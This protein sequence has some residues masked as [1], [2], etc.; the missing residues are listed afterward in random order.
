MID[1][2]TDCGDSAPAKLTR[3]FS[4]T[5]LPSGRVAGTVRVKAPTVLV[6]PTAM[7]PYDR[8]A[9]LIVTPGVEVLTWTLTPVATPSPRLVTGI[10][11]VADSPGSTNASPSVVGGDHRVVGDG[12]RLRRGAGARSA[13]SG[14]TMPKPVSRS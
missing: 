14:I 3:M 11:T 2:V 4:V 12:Q 5:V 8:L 1:F 6:A 7:F 13:R 10:V 9:G